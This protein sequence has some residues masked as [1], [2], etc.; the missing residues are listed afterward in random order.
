M[1]ATLRQGW[2]G[3]SERG[4]LS[5]GFGCQKS[6]AP[7]PICPCQLAWRMRTSPRP[8]GVGKLARASIAELE[9]VPGIGPQMAR[10][11]RARLGQGG[12]DG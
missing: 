4:G 1:V 5:T 9:E 6:R 12:E 3:C 7:R 8:V 2:P 10:Q 11:I